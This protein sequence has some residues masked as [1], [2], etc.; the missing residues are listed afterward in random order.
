MAR[1]ARG[2]KD[3]RAEAQRYIAQN[4]KARHN[5]IIEETI[6]GGLMLMGSEV[7]GLRSGGS[8]INEAYI[9]ADHG[10]LW[11]VNAHIPEYKFAHRDGHEARRPRK[12]L[13]HKRQMEKI[14]GAI[15]REGVTAVPLSL[16]FN[17]RGIAKVEIGIARGRKQHEKR[18][19]IKQRDWQREKAR[20]MRDRG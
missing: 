8:N 2:A 10:E 6:E 9:R 18:D 11:L 20:V 14:L 15:Q 1:A 19:M 3:A 12:V 5:Y 13:L 17:A 7:K 16:Y 4:R